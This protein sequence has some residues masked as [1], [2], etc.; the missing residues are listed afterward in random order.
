MMKN[1]RK[2]LLDIF[3]AGLNAVAGETVVK[4][5]LATGEYKKYSHFVA[6]GKAAESMLSG[7]PANQIGSALLIS[8]HAHISEQFYHNDKVTCIESD[9][10]IPKS[11]SIKAGNTLIKY[12]KNLPE[13]E[14]VLFLISGG[15]SALVEVLEDGWDLAQLQ[16]IT[17]YLLANA[18][19]IDEI[20]AVR[21][22]LSKIKGGGLWAYTGEHPIACLMISDVPDDDPAVIG[23]GLLFPIKEDSLPKISSEWADEL[24][25]PK[26][27]EVP[28]NFKWKII[29]SLDHAKE[30]AKIKAQELGY[31]VKVMPEF[32]KSEAETSAKDCVAILQENKNILC[33]WGGETT[34]KLPKNSGKGGRNQHLALAAAIAMQGHENTCLLSAGTDGSDGLTTATGA[35]VDGLTV[36]CGKQENMNALE[37]LNNADSNSF[38]KVTDSLITTGATGTNVMDLVIGIHNQ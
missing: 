35:M 24:G 2:N 32:L 10:P 29:A 12:L 1:T 33:I 25:E 15:T 6:I 4:K 20:N 31:Q 23:S 16:K 21:R 36:Q 5:A 18:Y 27:V 7:V 38:F 9:H 26:Q 3:Q 17:D 30:A 37:Y 8:K 34:V 13:K 11:S 28:D 14:P 19:S 22:R